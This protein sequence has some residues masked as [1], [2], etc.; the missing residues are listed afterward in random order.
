MA[1]PTRIDV[2]TAGTGF[3][4]I[5]SALVFRRYV[6]LHNNQALQLPMVLKLRDPSLF[7]H[8]RFVETLRHYCSWFWMGV[9]DIRCVPLPTLL[10]LVFLITVAG[11]ICMAALCSKGLLPGSRSGPIAAAVVFAAGMQPVLGGGTIVNSYAEHTSLAVVLLLGAFAAILLDR[12]Y[13]WALAFGLGFACNPMYGLHASVYFAVFGVVSLRAQRL[14]RR[15]LR[16]GLMA[17]ILLAPSL[18]W[19]V[20]TAQSVHPLGPSAVDTWYRVALCPA[21]FLDQHLFPQVWGHFA[22]IRHWILLGTAAC[23]AVCAPDQP[24]RTRLFIVAAAVASLVWLAVA[25]TAAY[26]IRSPSLLALH[27]GRGMD[28]FYALAGIYV[29]S[30]AFARCEARGATRASAAAAAGGLMAVALLL[31]TPH[32]LWTAAIFCVL[33]MCSLILSA[34]GRPGV[35]V[36]VGLLCLSLT[37]KAGLTTIRRLHDHQPLLCRSG[38]S[39]SLAGASEWALLHTNRDASFV[40]DPTIPELSFFRVLSLRSTFVTLR[41]GCAILWDGDYAADFERRLLDMGIELSIAD[42]LR[43]G[44]GYEGLT[45]RRL[46]ALAHHYG[47]QYALMPRGRGTGFPVLYANEMYEIIALSEG[48]PHPEQPSGPSTAGPKATGRPL[49][50]PRVIP[51]TPGG[52]YSAG[53]R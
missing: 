33:L 40:V 43:P 7:L 49:A 45:D 25:Y 18:A 28:L 38:V 24:L 5:L 3:A 22:I 21:I 34:R 4:T 6:Y 35:G 17:L 53:R 16:A 13:C 29:V 2:L 19:S 8:D 31:G 10:S 9:A 47:L 39:D 51:G 42:S 27:P 44:H 37:A 50:T 46:S 11:G 26:V 12:P 41:D 32:L 15:W 36:L 30:L 1:K 52:R 23:C 14:D 48:R 20:R